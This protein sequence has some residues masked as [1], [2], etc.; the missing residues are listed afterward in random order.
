MLD[1]VKGMQ[2]R[3]ITAPKKRQALICIYSRYLRNYQGIVCSTFRTKKVYFQ[4]KCNYIVADNKRSYKK[5]FLPSGKHR[6][7]ACCSVFSLFIK[8]DKSRFRSLEYSNYKEYH[9]RINQNQLSIVKP[10]V[11]LRLSFS[12]HIHQHIFAMFVCR[13]G[14]VQLYC[15]MMN[16]LRGTTSHHHSFEPPCSGSHELT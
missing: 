13:D 15:G 6:V 9:N 12:C 3:N 1:A 10:I 11:S 8:P 16:T 4:L 2:G 14:S 7:A 5:F